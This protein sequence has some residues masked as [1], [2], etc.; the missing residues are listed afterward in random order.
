MCLFLC[1]VNFSNAEIVEIFVSRNL[2]VEPMSVRLWLY[3]SRLSARHNSG[4]LSWSIKDA[5]YLYLYS[6]IWTGISPTVQGLCRFCS[7]FK[8]LVLFREACRE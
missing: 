1:L 7:V 8:T 5:T 3:Y 2:S 4:L 6:I